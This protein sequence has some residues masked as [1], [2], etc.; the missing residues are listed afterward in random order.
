MALQIAYVNFNTWEERWQ[1]MNVLSLNKRLGKEL[2]NL[3]NESRIKDTI[4]LSAEIN[5]IKNIHNTDGNK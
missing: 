1:K 5:E 3:A 4:N 2:Q